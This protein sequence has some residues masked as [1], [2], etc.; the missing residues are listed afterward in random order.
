MPDRDLILLVE[1]DQE[2]ASALA[3]ELEHE[4]YEVAVERDGLAGLAAVGRRSPELIV[5]DVM[6]PSISGIELCRR[7][8]T[9]ASTPILML[10]ARNAVSDRVDGLDAGADDYL[11]KPF[12]LEELLARVRACMRRNRR[13]LSGGRL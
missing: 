11:A 8:R 10:T 13:S 6:L 5:L 12:S 4:G 9:R 2:I 7:V 1:D 3:L